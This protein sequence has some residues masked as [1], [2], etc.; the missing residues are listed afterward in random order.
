MIF[1][2]TRCGRD[3]L[4]ADEMVVDRRR[5]H[6]VGSWCR[7]CQKKASQTSRATRSVEER[8]ARDNDWHHRTKE[9][10]QRK[11]KIADGR[12]KVRYG[13]SLEEYEAMV[14]R[15]GGACAICGSVR[16]LAI[17]HCHETGR[18][19]GLLCYPCNIKLSGMEDVAWAAQAEV[20]LLRPAV[21]EELVWGLNRPDPLLVAAM[22]RTEQCEHERQRD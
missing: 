15:Q 4:T 7:A 5:R 21:V 17:D 20:Y 14:E 6:D 2:C 22:E 8:R 11:R 1:T 13:I 19:R 16:K 18:V 10:D 9:T 3:D 12:L